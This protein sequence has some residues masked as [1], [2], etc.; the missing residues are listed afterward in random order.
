[1]RSRLACA[2]IVLGCF[3]NVT[4]SSSPNTSENNSGNGRMLSNFFGGLL[5]TTNECRAF[6]RPFIGFV[7]KCVIYIGSLISTVWFLVDAFRYDKESVGMAVA[8]IIGS[9]ISYCEVSGFF[10]RIQ[11]GL[12]NNEQNCTPMKI[13]RKCVIFTGLVIFAIWLLIDGLYNG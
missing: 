5:E 8:F 9:V 4:F 10:D 2:L 12:V 6:S 7:R 3:I 1:M 13:T 11:V